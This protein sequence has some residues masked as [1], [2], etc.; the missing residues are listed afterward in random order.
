MN[1]LTTL[2]AV[3][4]SVTDNMNYRDQIETHSPISIPG[5]EGIAIP[6]GSHGYILKL[7]EDDAALVRWEVKYL[8][9]STVLTY[10]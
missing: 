2:Y 9:Y 8:F 4:R 10:I 7:L 6:S 5:I 1:G 3:S